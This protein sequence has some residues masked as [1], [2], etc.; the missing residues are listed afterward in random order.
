MLNRFGFERHFAT[1]TL[2]ILNL[3]AVDLTYCLLSLPAQAV[4]KLTRSFPFGDVPTQILAIFST[5]NGYVSWMSV[6]LVAL[7]RCL[8]ILNF[9]NNLSTSCS[10]G[11]TIGVIF[12]LLWVY[13]FSIL[14]PILFG[15]IWKKNGRFWDKICFEKSFFVRDL[16]SLLGAVT[17]DLSPFLPSTIVAKS[18]TGI[19]CTLKEFKHT[20]SGSSHYP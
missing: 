20:L 19:T 4:Q 8:F 13:G 7:S 9:W 11:W 2:F 5:I 16:L 3:A 17:L 12:G 15:V 6:A 1:T 10:L 14:V 18:N